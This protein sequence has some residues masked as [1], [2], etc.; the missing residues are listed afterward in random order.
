MS[1]AYKDKR[2]GADSPSEVGTLGL[3]GDIASDGATGANYIKSQV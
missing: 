3:K 2:G 1:S